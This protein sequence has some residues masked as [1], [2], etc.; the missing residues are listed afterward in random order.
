[1][2]RKGRSHDL[3]EDIQQLLR[4]RQQLLLQLS[5]AL[6]H[7]GRMI[8]DHV[9]RQKDPHVHLLGWRI[10]LLNLVH[11]VAHAMKALKAVLCAAD[12]CFLPEILYQPLKPAN[13]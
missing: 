1:M 13:T 7:V 5:H 11:K 8:H 9:H 3:L 6:K 10:F 2:H 4:R 12:R